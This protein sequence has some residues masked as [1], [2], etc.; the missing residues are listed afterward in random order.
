MQFW[1]QFTFLVGMLAFIMTHLEP[2]IDE[3]LPTIIR[4]NTFYADL[5]AFLDACRHRPKIYLRIPFH[6]HNNV[7][8]LNITKVGNLAGKYTCMEGKNT[9]KQIRLTAQLLRKIL[10]IMCKVC[11]RYF[12]LNFTCFL[13]FLLRKVYRR[14][15]NYI[16]IKLGQPTD[17]I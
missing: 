11:Y 8:I 12:L 16:K 17:A 15:P 2:L 4:R 1:L 5:L 3:L 13:A 10:H 9:E 14:T 7:F 6:I